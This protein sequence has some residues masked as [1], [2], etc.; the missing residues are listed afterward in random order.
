MSEVDIYQCRSSSGALIGAERRLASSQ[1]H[2]LLNNDESALTGCCRSMSA[3]CKLEFATLRRRT[4]HR[5]ACGRRTARA[6]PVPTFGS[7]L[8]RGTRA[9]CGRA[10]RTRKPLG[11]PPCCRGSGPFRQLRSLSA[12]WAL[13]GLRRH[14]GELGRIH[15]IL[16]TSAIYLRTSACRRKN[17]RPPVVLPSLPPKGL[18]FT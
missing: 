8:L 12:C 18:R 3:D 4:A 13:P 5:A 6:V 1:V 15:G 10:K 14:T 9:K 7:P 17:G 11:V 2:A 16:R